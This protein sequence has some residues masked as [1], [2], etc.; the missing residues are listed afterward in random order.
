MIADDRD[1][2][3]EHAPV[4]PIAVVGIGASAGGLQAYTELLEA[5]PADTGMTFVIV[6]HMAAGHESFLSTLL[7]R[8]A[9]MPT[10]VTASTPTSFH[11]F[12]VCSGRQ[13]ARW[14]ILKE[15]SASA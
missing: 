15:A 14:L 9:S 1:D 3:H 2:H 6:Q 13:T 5:L 4:S 12:L 10:T 11:A 7:G 8:V